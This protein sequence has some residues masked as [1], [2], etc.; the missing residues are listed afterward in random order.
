MSTTQTSSGT[1]GQA[2][3]TGP[4]FR[5]ELVG[6]DEVVHL[7]SG[8]EG[9]PLRAHR[10]AALQ[11]LEDKALGEEG[12]ARAEREL[13]RCRELIAQ[14]LGGD[15]DAVAILGNA[16]DALHRLIHS[17]RYPEGANVV[18]TDLE[19]SSGVLSLLVLRDQG[20]EVRIVPSRDGV[21][22]LD[23]LAAAIDERTALVLCSATSYINGARIDAPAVYDLAKAAGAAFVLDATQSLGVVPVSA[24]WADAVVSSSYK[25]LLGPQGLGF[26]HLTRPEM[27]ERVSAGAGWRSVDDVFADD[28]YERIHLLPSARRWELGFPSF[29]GAYVINRS[30]ELLTGVDPIA[31]ERHVM[32]LGDRLVAGLTESGA[33]LLSPRE[34]ALRSA[35]ISVRTEHGDRVAAAMLDAGVRA[36]GGDGRVRFSIHGFADADGIDAAVRAFRA[37]Q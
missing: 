6:I 24:A 23:D 22:E 27:F 16:S 29:L 34:R 31:L 10:E 14:L 26:L 19:F 30:L 32:E 21:I 12:R 33:E 9:P 11:F 35:N 8:A 18:T 3:G 7:Y 28:R 25:W 37:T 36:W 2:A 13:R 1:T 5:D 17:I 20:V 4:W 15:P